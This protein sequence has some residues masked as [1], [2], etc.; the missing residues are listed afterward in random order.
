MPTESSRLGLAIGGASFARRKGVRFFFD[1]I[2]FLT[3]GSAFASRIPLI[4]EGS[5]RSQA[6][7]SI[8]SSPSRTPARAS[9]PFMY[10]T[11]CMRFPFLGY[12]AG[13]EHL[14]MLSL[15]QRSSSLWR[16]PR[17]TGG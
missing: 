3:R 2:S 13:V 12:V 8:M 16:Q 15:R 17:L 4:V 6:L 5:E 9:L 11:R 14:F 10:I 1:L 7:M